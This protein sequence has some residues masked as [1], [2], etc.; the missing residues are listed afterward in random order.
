MAAGFA[1][2]I[3]KR[4]KARLVLISSKR[5]NNKLRDFYQSSDRFRGYVDRCAASDG[6]TAEEILSRALTREVSRS[7]MDERPGSVLASGYMPMGEC[8]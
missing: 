3:I 7:Y 4:C 5:E 1:K 8:V 6:V 2:L